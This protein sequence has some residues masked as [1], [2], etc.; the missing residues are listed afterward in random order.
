MFNR[1]ALLSAAH[2]VGDPS[3]LSADHQIA[4]MLRLLAGRKLK[5]PK[6]AT[7]AFQYSFKARALEVLAPVI[8]E[9][10]AA[11]PDGQGAE[12][13]KRLLSAPQR[14]Y[15]LQEDDSA[16][17]RTA[18]V[19][20]FSFAAATPVVVVARLRAPRRP[21]DWPR[22]VELDVRC[23]AED[24]AAGIVGEAERL[25]L[26]RVTAERFLPDSP[27]GARPALWV[28][29][30]NDEVQV[31]G[32]MDRIRA[33]GVVRGHLF[34]VVQQ[35]IRRFAQVTKLLAESSGAAILWTPYCGPGYTEL[36][37]AVKPRPCVLV[38]EP[39]FD[40]ALDAA[41]KGL[42]DIGPAE[43]PAVGRDRDLPQP[44]ETRHYKKIYARR[45]GGDMMV[46]RGDCNHNR[47]TVARGAP[48]AELGIAKLEDGVP[49]TKFEKCLSCEGGGVW[50]VTF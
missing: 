33:T 17:L 32:W 14:V 6:D 11:L 46:H 15:A 20:A 5:T 19:S 31:D 22:D 30:S 23:Y 39:A 42:N 35:P 9:A 4:Q 26:E 45:G 40:L 18:M 12:A 28:G 29:G 24:D 13:I 25:T 16:L 37:A 8:A 21:R 1:G 2:P 38:H 49:W 34:D 10:V 48:Q 47:W 27:A 36:E 44:G 50:R 3:G 43:E 7:G 41:R